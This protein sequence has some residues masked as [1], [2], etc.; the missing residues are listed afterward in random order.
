VTCCQRIFNKIHWVRSF[1]RGKPVG[2]EKKSGVIAWNRNSGISAINVAYHFGAKT[3]VLLGFD[4]K[5]ENGDFNWHK[6]H[7]EMK[8]S[9]N[10]EKR[11]DRIFNR[12]LKCIPS[13]AADA[14]QLGLRVINANPESVIEHFEKM[15]LD[16]AMR[17]PDGVS[18]HI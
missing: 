16:D 7:V 5:S 12:F 11:G 4:M 8:L 6:S 14:Q 1:I 17:L 13:V 2:I 18:G 10:L 15:S 3:V 9:R